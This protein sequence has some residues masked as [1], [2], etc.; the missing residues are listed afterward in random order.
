MRRSALFAL[1]VALAL[2]PVAA[3]PAGAAPAAKTNLEAIE[4]YGSPTSAQ[5]E[6]G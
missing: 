2:V 5:P 3:A 6:S 1:V 4:C